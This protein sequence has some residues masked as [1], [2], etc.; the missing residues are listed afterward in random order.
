MTLGLDAL[1]GFVSSTALVMNL[2]SFL[3]PVEYR[4]IFSTVISLRNANDPTQNLNIDFHGQCSLDGEAVSCGD[5]LLAVYQASL[6]GYESD[7]DLAT[8]QSLL[9][10]LRP[11][12]ASYTICKPLFAWE[13]DV[14]M[15]SL[16]TTASGLL[17]AVD[18]RVD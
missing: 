8:V 12:C 2:G 16:R 3:L 10:M 1:I 6:G 13:E 9:K 15:D 7:D 5:T 11:L 4:G 17:R 14:L 18:V